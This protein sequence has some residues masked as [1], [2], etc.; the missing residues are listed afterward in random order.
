[1]SRATAGIIVGSL[2]LA[3]CSG[4]V[5][6]TEGQ[7]SAGSG[8]STATGGSAGGGGS[9]GSGASPSTCAADEEM[10]EGR[11][12]DPARRYEP[13][14]RVDFDNVVV[15]GAVSSTLDLPEPP[16]SGFRLI[17]APRQ[18]APGDEQNGCLAW[19]YPSI[20]HRF[21][22][23]ARLY[24]TTGLH[25]SNMYGMP[26]HNTLG[27]SPYPQCNPGQSDIVA[28]AADILAGSIPDVLFANSTQVVGGEA[29]VFAPG[30]A[31]ELQI[32]GR[33]ITTSIHFLNPGAESIDVEVVYDFFTMPEELVTTELVPYYFDNFSF[34]IPAETTGVVE[35]TCPL[36]GGNLVTMMP[37]AHKRTT[38]FTV[39]LLAGDGTETRVFVDGAFDADSDIRIFA[40]PI[41][42]VGKTQIRHR[43]TVA[44]ELSLPIDYGFGEDE[45]C[46]LFGYMFP[47]EAQTLGVVQSGSSCFGA[48]I[49]STRQ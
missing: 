28:H 7:G 17:V 49:G 1:M 30:M 26:L 35:T 14:E 12:V 32:E 20:R 48:N 36:F 16:K 6:S 33:E 19:P 3:S 47:P 38:E 45:M 24:T 15:F 25:H 42:L 46:T 11:C 27:P 31:Y 21:V 40:E 22:Y 41:S 9:A 43:C 37:H 13:D 44:N 8:G 18:L 23:A 29:I 39:D 2:L 34:E 4:G 10:F 5:A